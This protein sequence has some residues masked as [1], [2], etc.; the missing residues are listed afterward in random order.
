M[1]INSNAISC[2]ASIGKNTRFFHHGLGCCIHEDT[3]IGNHCC[4]F[5]NVT[6][7]QRLS[8]QNGDGVPVIGNNVVIGAGAV[9]L[10]KI[11]IGNNVTIG[12]N[13]VVVH[14]VPDNSI[15]VGVPA[16]IKIKEEEAK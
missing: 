16:R 1:I 11:T 5:Q 6:I 4:I 10:G 12:A 14:S 9:I 3:I 2:R 13:A 8:G 15:A 7:G